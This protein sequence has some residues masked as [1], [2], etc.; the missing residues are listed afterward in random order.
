[1][2]RGGRQRYIKCFY[3]QFFLLIEKNDQTKGLRVE[4][5]DKGGGVHGCDR[6]SLCE[7]GEG[8]NNME[9]CVD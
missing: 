4:R 6:M 2:K 1:M 7:L 8:E 9:G 3:Q 5:E